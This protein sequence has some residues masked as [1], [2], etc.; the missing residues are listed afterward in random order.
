M[1]NLRFNNARSAGGNAAARL[2][3]AQNCYLLASGHIEDNNWDNARD[4]LLRALAHHPA[5]ADAL[6]ALANLEFTVGD[7]PQ[8][9]SYLDRLLMLPEPAD[10]ETLFVQGNVEL[11]EGNLTDALAAYAR[12]EKMAGSTPELEFNKGLAHLML[13]HGEEATTIF[14]RLVEEQPSNARAWDA[15]GCALRLDKHYDEASAAFMQA[16]TV[17]PDQ[18]DTRDHMAQMLL[19]MGDPRRARLVLEAALTIDAERASTRHLLGLTD[20]TAQ[21]FPSAIACWEELIARGG[22]LPETYHL[23]ANA[24]LRLNDRPHA[25]AVLQTLIALVPN[26]LPGQLQ[27]ALL[28][29]EQGEFTQG[30]RHLEQ[31]RAIDPQNPAVTQLVS[32][33]NAMHPQRDSRDM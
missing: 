9:R 7:I 28:L 29:L 19:E 12:S 3:H 11:S 32:V 1:A 30:W 21:D 8:A 4:L 26:H 33:A 15:L 6:R 22:A 16:L 23:L 10:A 24:Y 13:G 18:N 20:A 2:R 5:H 27:L 31:A 14:T 25:I 17:A